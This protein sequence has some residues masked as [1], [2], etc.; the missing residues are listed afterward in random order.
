MTRQG[1][2]VVWGGIALLAAGRLVGISELYV[3]GAAALVLVVL[4]VVYVNRSEEHTSEL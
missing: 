3:F 1:W 2:M 4:A